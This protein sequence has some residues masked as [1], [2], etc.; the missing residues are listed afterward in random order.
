MSAADSNAK[1]S[2]LNCQPQYQRTNSADEIEAFEVNVMHP[3]SAWLGSFPVGSTIVMFGLW[4]A[5]DPISSKSK[6]AG[7]PSRG[8]TFLT[9]KLTL[10]PKFK[11]Q[12]VEAT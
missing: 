9:H 4:K 10:F 5:S 8:M 3:D 12:V 1:N 6:G 11:R 7:S 2:I